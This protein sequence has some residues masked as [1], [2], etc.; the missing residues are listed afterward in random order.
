MIP[1]SSKVTVFLELLV[2]GLAL[3]MDAFAVTISNSCAYPNA[4]RGQRLAMPVVFGLFQ[5]IMPLVG[6]LIGSFASS[7]IDRYAGFVALVILGVIGGRM[8]WGGY[9]ALR[10]AQAGRGPCAT[11]DAEVGG[12]GGGAGA[13][14][15]G[16]GAETAHPGTG[17]ATPDS[18]AGGGR[19][20][21]AGALLAQGVATSIDALIVGV[22]FLALG[23]NIAVAAPL[24][25]VTTFMCC[26]AALALGRRFGVLLGDKA[27]IVGG[28]VLI[29]I[30]IKA[31]F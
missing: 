16:V 17:M 6:Y 30:G 9:H 2:I 31:L 10:E 22:S 20:L 12:A 18:T 15:P 3:S 21:S 8:V 27:E 28:I 26:L 1:G 7:L 19:K 29:L 23:A 13:S 14:H 24:V 11:S 4:S 25:A 5:G